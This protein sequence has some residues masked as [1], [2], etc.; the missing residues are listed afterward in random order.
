M[1]R[2]ILFPLVAAGLFAMEAPA[3]GQTRITIG[4]PAQ[5]FPPGLFSDGGQYKV[6]DFK[7]KLL[8][9]YF[10]ESTCP[11]CRASVPERSATV[12]A[13]KGKPVKFLAVAPNTTLLQAQI[14]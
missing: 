3:G 9:V 5:D 8:V 7:D 6:S 13:F 14:Y 12:M 11:R 1:R 2:L 10:F 4:E